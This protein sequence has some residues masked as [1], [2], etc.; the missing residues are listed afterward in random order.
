M[1]VAPPSTENLLVIATRYHQAGQLEQA[2]AVYREALAQNPHCFDALHMLGVIAYQQGDLA[3]ARQLLEQALAGSGEVPDMLSNYALILS[4]AGPAPTLENC[5]RRLIAAAPEDADAR[6]KLG[7]LLREQGDSHGAIACYRDAVALRPSFAEAYYNLGLTLADG[8]DWQ[9]AA[10]HWQRCLG[11]RPD[12][13]AAH[14]SLGHAHQQDGDYARAIQSYRA[15]IGFDENYPEAHY[16]LGNALR[17][18]HR[19]EA[20]T[21]CYRRAIA[22]RPEY[23]EAWNNLGSTLKTQGRMGEALEAFRHALAVRPDFSM[24]HSNLIYSAL[25]LPETTPATVLRQ[26]REWNERHGECGDIAPP[27]FLN[28]RRRRPRIGFVSG[29]FRTHPVGHLVIRPLEALR[30]AGP[31]PSLRGRIKEA[32]GLPWCEIICYANQWEEDDLTRRFMAAAD[33]WRNVLGMDDAALAELIREDRVDILFDLTGHNARNRLPAFARKPAPIQISWAG[34]M[35][36]T[37]LD[38]MDYLITDDHE[39]PASACADYA[40]RL[41]RMPDAFICYDPPAYA[42]AVAPP[43]CLATGCIT[44]GSFNILSK[45]TPQ[46]VAV[47]SEVL[48]R[49]SGSRLLLKT[50]ALECSATRQRYTDQFRQHGIGEDRLLIEGRSPHA[51]HLARYE[52]VDIALDPFPFTGSTTTLEALWIG[53]PVLT[54]PGQT[55][56]ARHSLSTLANLGLHEWVARNPADYV[57]RAAQRAADPAAL[58]KLRAGLRQRMAASPLCDGPRFA[59]AL[60]RELEAMISRLP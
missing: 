51:A 48:H 41:V 47:W 23:A 31:A 49:V 57:E 34:Y 5:Y 12:W 60:R 29:D 20:A 21:A 45:I 50:P 58:A 38:A 16:N 28:R 26:H 7:N 11:L 24:A 3:T 52:A 18:T 37:G 56:P 19:L 9:E 13:A 6:Y 33:A 30:R 54:W 40:E 4:R 59:R 2:A 36:T 32:L 35:A 1:S 8:G 27:P 10:A 15:A 46:V 17:E 14:N 22:L 42:P 53:V 43:P 25:F 44:F 55:F 39:T